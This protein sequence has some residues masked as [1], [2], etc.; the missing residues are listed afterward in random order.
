MTIKKAFLILMEIAKERKGVEILN[1]FGFMEFGMGYVK[2]L[3]DKKLDREGQYMEIRNVVEGIIGKLVD[4][5]GF[6]EEKSVL[7]TGT[8]NKENIS[9]PTSF[10]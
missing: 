7:L 10:Q 1:S 2:N 6:R 3:K 8:I 9:N 5:N 4:F